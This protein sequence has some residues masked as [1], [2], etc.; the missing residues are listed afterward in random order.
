MR[1]II[2]L[3]FFLVFTSSHS[4]VYYKDTGWKLEPDG[5]GVY[6]VLPDK[7]RGGATTTGCTTISCT[8]GGSVGGPL[9]KPRPTMTPTTTFPKGN[10]ASAALG[11]GTRILPWLA[12]GQGLYDWY[13]AA[14]LQ[15][16]QEGNP[17]ET[18]GGTTAATQSWRALSDVNGYTSTSKLYSNHSAVCQA[19]K[20]ALTQSMNNTGVFSSFTLNLQI[21]QLSPTQYECRFSGPWVRTNGTTGNVDSAYGTALFDSGVSRCFDSSGSFVVNPTGGLCPQGVQTPVTQANAQQR[22]NNAAIT[23]DVLRRSFDDVLDAGGGIVSTGTQVTGPSSAPGE[24]TTRTTTASNGTTQVSTTTTNYN[25]TYNDNRVTVTETKTTQNPDGSTE[26]ETTD[27]PKDDC[28]R[29]PEALKCKELGQETGSPTWETKTVTFQAENLG[30]S[31][32][33]PAPWVANLRGWN[34]TMSYQPV[35][36]VA[37]TVRLGLLAVTALM[38]IFVVIRVTQS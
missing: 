27:Q 34:L 29:N 21:I 26:T 12:V 1:N 20:T 30:L 11:L 13:N 4:A 7:G 23:A 5:N 22:L 14:G 10:I 37:P 9:G 16:D 33:C 31:G 28:A 19:Y 6:S 8:R 38:C 35:C 25:Y 15:V 3:L 18:S 36:D 17:T 24:T 32:S 2:T